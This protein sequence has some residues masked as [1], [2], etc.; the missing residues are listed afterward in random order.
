VQ[1]APVGQK[2]AAAAAAGAAGA[3]GTRAREGATVVTRQ[4]A[5]MAARPSA[6]ILLGAET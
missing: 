4:T 6:W 2:S 5:A 3:A 1:P